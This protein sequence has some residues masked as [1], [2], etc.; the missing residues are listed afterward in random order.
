[1]GEHDLTD[2][3]TT[4]LDIL[5]AIHSLTVEANAD[6]DHD[7]ATKQ[8][9][10]IWESLDDDLELSLVNHWTDIINNRGIQIRIEI[11]G[12]SLIEDE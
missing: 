5:Q 8:I 9:D 12:Y 6:A 3:T 10:M 11:T 1:M 7:F 4:A 2:I